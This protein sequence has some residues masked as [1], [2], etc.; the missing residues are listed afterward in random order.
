MNINHEG[1]LFCNRM[2]I[3]IIV[4]RLFPGYGAAK[5]VALGMKIILDRV[6]LK[7]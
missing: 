6:A 2:I 7:K 5:I 3:Y 1:I 4:P